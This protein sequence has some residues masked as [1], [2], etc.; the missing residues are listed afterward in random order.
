MR[1][2]LLAWMGLWVASSAHAVVVTIDGVHVVEASAMG[3][4]KWV[5]QGGRTEGESEQ[6]YIKR[7]K[8]DSK[9]QAK[10]AADRGTE[11]HGYIE[12]GFRGEMFEDGYKYYMSVSDTIF[13]E[14]GKQEWS[15]EKSFAISLGYGGK[16]DLHSDEY[17]IDFKG[18]DKPLE[19]LKLW[20]D[21]Y[22]QLAAYE[23]GISNNML[24]CGICYVHRE[25]AESRLIWADRKELD[26]GW[27]M[28]LAL[29]DY[30][31]IKTGLDR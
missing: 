1:V 9:A 6:D 18:T 8:E 29:L 27:K 31:L 28:F 4:G 16:T 11:I 15:T 12:R 20:D 10:A 3:D 5:A 25:T 21:H 13:K 17:L 19:S 14:C 23:R 2:L 26:K 7:I 24:K 30:Y 22:L